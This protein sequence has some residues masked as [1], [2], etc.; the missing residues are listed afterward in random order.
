MQLVLGVISGV[1]FLKLKG[2]NTMAFF[3]LFVLF[4]SIMKKL[5]AR[6]LN[7]YID[8]CL[9]SCIYANCVNLFVP[10]LVHG[11]SCAGW[12]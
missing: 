2:T 8:W 3:L 9:C 7:I 12:W 4:L 10:E 1:S 6:N 5:V 11:I